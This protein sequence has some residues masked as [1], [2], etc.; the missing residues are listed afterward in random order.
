MAEF[1]RIS[2]VAGMR[3]QAGG[4]ERRHVGC[5]YAEMIMKHPSAQQV[6]MYWMKG[7]IS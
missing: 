6:R 1:W 3:K 2:E 5:R 7:I 4:K